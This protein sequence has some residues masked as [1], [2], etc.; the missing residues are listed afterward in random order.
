[1]LGI[2]RR[3]SYDLS[4]FMRDLVRSRHVIAELTNKDFRSRYLGS[5][6]GLLW[7]FIHPTATIGIIWFVFTHG[8]KA[9]PVHGTPFILWLMAGMVPWFFFAEGLGS[10]TNSILENQ[11]LV[12]KVV[13]RVSLLPVVK[14]L[15]ALFIHLV[16]VILM[17]IILTVHGSWP[18]WYA[19]QLLY[20]L[21][22]MV[23]LLLGLS[24]FTSSLTVFARDLGQATSVVLQFGVW[25][26]PIMWNIE[27]I[28]PQ[29]RIF[30]EINPVFYIVT[31]YRNSL[32]DEVWVWEQG[33]QTLYFWL[34][35]GIFMLLGTF[36][37]RR[38]RPHFA[39]VL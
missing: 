21:P 36:V 11:V 33:W 25:A 19:I 1:M 20:Y 10:A 8:L 12:K 16:F 7:A 18:G 5:Y 13:F 26:T 39:D 15:S 29:Y 24:W 6:L 22:A 23:V 9:G 3:I 35:A 28:P 4:Q 34:A 14:L 37:F 27:M 32:I 38:L 30:F 31:G 17:I 2:M